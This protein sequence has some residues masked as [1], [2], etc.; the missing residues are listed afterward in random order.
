[1]NSFKFFSFFPNLFHSFLNVLI[2]N[3]RFFFNYFY[4]N[5]LF[6]LTSRGPFDSFQPRLIETIVLIIDFTLLNFLKQLVFDFNHKII[7]FFQINLSLNL[8]DLFLSFEKLIFK[9]VFKRWLL[10]YH[11]SFVNSIVRKCYFLKLMVIH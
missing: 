1:M 6:G 7:C 5:L 8:W 2:W 11:F 4:L 10:Y 3:F 9:I